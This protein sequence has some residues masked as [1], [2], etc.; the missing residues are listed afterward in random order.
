MIN[1]ITPPILLGIERRIAYANRKYHSGWIW[2]GVNIGLAGMKFSGSVE[3]NGLIDIIKKNNLKIKIDPIKSFLVKNGWKLILSL[4]ILMEIGFEEPVS[5][6]KIIWM[7]DMNAITNGKI[8]WR[9]KNRVNVGALTE[10]PP[11][12][13]IT[14]WFPQIGIAD[15]KLVITVAA[16]NDICPHGKIYPKNAVAIN[17]KT[18]ITPAFQ[19]LFNKNELIIKFF[20]IWE[21]RKIKNIDAPL[22]WMFRKSQPLLTFRLSLITELNASSEYEE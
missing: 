5:W 13:Q 11:Q 22:M 2:I 16:Q 21:N 10:N 18:I 6:I 7:I 12:I 15:I 8:K 4:F 1:A 20:E 3:M 19:G 14:I 17:R 9:E